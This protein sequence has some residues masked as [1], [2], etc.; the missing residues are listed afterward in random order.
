MVR[1]LLLAFYALIITVGVLYPG[2]H[3]A[4]AQMP[5]SVSFDDDFDV[6]EEPQVSFQTTV[7]KK[8]VAANQPFKI[9]MELKNAEAYSAPDTSIFPSGIKI[10]TQTQ[11]SSMVIVNGV[12]NRVTSWLF[13]V[14]AETAGAY[15]IPAIS[16][17]TDLGTLYSQPFNVYAKDAS[18]LPASTEDGTVIIESVIEK[19]DPY[20]GEPIEYTTKLYHLYPIDHAELVK[21]KSDNAIIEQ[22][23]EP[24]KSQTSLNGKQYNML[25]VSYIITPKKAGKVVISPSI[26]RGKILKEVKKER[27]RT[28]FDNFFDPFSV[29]DKAISVTRELSTFTVASNKATLSVKAPIDGVNPW[30]AL[31]DLSIEDEILDT[32]SGSSSS[33]KAKV[34][35]PISRKIVMTAIGRTGEDLPDIENFIKADNFK[36]Y[37]DKPESEKKILTD[38]KGKIASKIKGIK[39]QSFTFIPEKQGK[40]TLPD[41]KV[42]YVDIKDGKVKYAILPGKILDV[43]PSDNG[44]ANGGYD[45]KKYNKSDIGKGDDDYIGDA[46][47]GENSTSSG[48]ISWF[49]IILSIILLLVIIY[50]I[51]KTRRLSSDS[52]VVDSSSFDAAIAGKIT[53]YGVAKSQKVSGITNSSIKAIIS[54][55]ESAPNFEVMEKAVK[56]FARQDLGIMSDV[57]VTL[58]SQQISKKYKLNKGELLRVFSDLDS[59]IYSGK[60]IDLEELRKE[61]IVILKKIG[62]KSID[63]KSL[64]PLNPI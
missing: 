43:A 53:E 20:L 28:A 24:S 8:S 29:I 61:L 51:L 27:P 10:Q 37:S 6:R 49:N 54:S 36:V 2:M 7:D 32:S 64:P 63:N 38:V 48:S 14:I 45:P 22:I 33:I 34:G 60:K 31:Y 40:V 19:K 4:E 35:E 16:I 56:S 58:I 17:Q 59:A 13:E 12:Q 11:H 26:L 15:S 57:S 47:N 1:F 23:T 18:D 5:F 50:F 3:N 39:T 25:E 52:S 55:I 62:D 30:L 42:A 9:K 41:I 46:A 21:P 44:G